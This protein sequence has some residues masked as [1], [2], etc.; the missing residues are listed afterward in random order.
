MAMLDDDLQELK[1][2]P[3]RV[4][5][6]ELQVVLLRDDLAEQRQETR[7]GFVAANERFDRVDARF[8]RTDARIESGDVEMRAYVMELYADLVQRIHDGD[9]NTLRAVE[10]AKQ[11]LRGEMVD[12]GRM[13]RSEIHEQVGDTRRLMLS[14]HQEMLGLHQQLLARFDRVEKRLPAARE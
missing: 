2:L 1:S 14:L 5:S 11:T 8:D 13:L 4:D 10:D 9:Q 3:T 12:M 7:A 6:L